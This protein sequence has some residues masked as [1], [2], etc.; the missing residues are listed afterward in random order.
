MAAWLEGGKA[1]LRPGTRS[2]AQ[3]A[4]SLGAQI[5]E[6][7]GHG[8]GL[9]G[10]PVDVDAARTRIDSTFACTGTTRMFEAAGFRRIAQTG[11]RSAGLPPRRHAARPNH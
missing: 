9:E 8:S 2:N 11:A 5:V 6:D 3:P 4:A 7:Y 1:V 10:Y